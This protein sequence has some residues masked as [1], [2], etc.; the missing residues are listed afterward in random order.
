V[1]DDMLI[2]LVGAGV[3]L[4]REQSKA[5]SRDKPHK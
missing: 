3:L 2:E 1:F 4:R 5:V